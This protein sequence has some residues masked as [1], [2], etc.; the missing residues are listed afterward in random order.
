[1]TE[2][3]GYLTKERQMLR[4][5]AREFTT[6]EVLPV[7][8][9]LDPV[10]GIIPDSLVEKLGEMGYFGI[11]IPEKYGGAGLGAFEYCL[12]AEELARGW[13][14]VASLIARGNG[15]YRA[16]PGDGEEREEKIA[17][18]ARGEYLGALA[19]SE[20]DVGSDLAS[21]QCRAERDGDE[22]VITGNKYW[23]TFAT[24]PTS[25]R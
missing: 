7:A 2:A 4:D 25:S 16:I 13:M 11:V 14:S 12:V 10:K 24:V 15:F 22:W 6:K 20:P 8:N 1:M 17:R 9:E 18:M 19:M 5:T 23:C 3:T 21:I